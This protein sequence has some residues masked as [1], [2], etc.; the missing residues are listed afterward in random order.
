MLFL[1]AISVIVRGGLD[2]RDVLNQMVDIGSDSIWIVM[3]IT[4]ST[5]FVFAFY[6]VNL[7]LQIGVTQFIGG[8]LA[9][10]FFSELGPTLTG[11]AV[12]S[13][14]GA[15]IAAEIGSMVV[16]E[17]VD[18]LRAMAVSPIRYLVAPRLVA[19][20]VMMPML[21][22]IADTSGIVGAYILSRINGIP[23]SVFWDSVHKYLGANDMARGILKSLFF[24]VII[25]IGGCYEGLQTSGGATGV[26]RATT[27]SVVRCVVL[28][29]I[30]NFFLTEVMTKISVVH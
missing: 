15:A 12:A 17:Q 11:A 25:S 22:I 29:F 6:T 7:S 21:T 5:G 1:Q 4:T 2:M 18:A 3:T 19:A 26:G 23:H 30:S 13:R 10:V 27:R 9:Y 20:V 14:S 24:G 8:T 16:T 28:I